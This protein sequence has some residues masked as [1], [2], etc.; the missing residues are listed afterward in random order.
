[1]LQVCA[2]E[3]CCDTLYVPLSS[4]PSRA[5]PVLAVVTKERGVS[6]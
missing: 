5:I 3:P 4:Y 2:P 6:L 1:M